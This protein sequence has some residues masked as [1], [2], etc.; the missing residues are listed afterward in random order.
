MKKRHNKKRNIAFVYEA[1]VREA[2]VAVMR[3]DIERRKKVFKIIKEHFGEQSLLKRELQ[4]YRSLYENQNLDETTSQKILLEARM[5]R[6]AIDPNGLFKQKTELI[7]K[8][9]QDLSPSIFNNFVPNYKSLATISQ[10][11]STKTSPKTRVMMEQQ[12]IAAMGRQPPTED[13]PEI[14][15]VVYQS[16][17]KKFNDKY[18]A[19]LLDEQ[20]ELLAHYISSFSDNALQ[21]KMFLNEEISRLKREL[22]EAKNIS[23]IREDK[24]MLNKTTQV[25]E[26]LNG[27][28]KTEISEHLLL[29]VL[30]I[31]SL[32]KEINTDANHD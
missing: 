16:F 30:N 29:K 19:E 23:E 1:L 22:D 24:E 14:D 27:F 13:T 31:Q 26:K 12:V 18:G 25:V 28:A 15:N 5:Q 3:K 8:I 21:L 4:C 2:T 7:K 9:N 11:F 17:V 6:R 10:I 20:K 32:L